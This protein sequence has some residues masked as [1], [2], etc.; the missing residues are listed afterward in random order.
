M[1]KLNQFF[2]SRKG[3]AVI[4][5]RLVIGW[6]LIAGV[7]PYVSQS[8]P[9]SEV[10][11]FFTQLH[12][13]APLLSAYLSVYTQF[14]CGILFII[15]LWVRPAA[16]VLIINF[17]IAIITAH[18]NEGIEKSFAAWIILAGSLLFLFNGA[19]KISLD[20]R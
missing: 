16:V 10:K 17:A 20:N 2:E 7:W 11:D 9:M 8:K 19:G 15:G 1:K 4:F 12:L 13:P 14:I 18:L 6:R 3:Y 5:L